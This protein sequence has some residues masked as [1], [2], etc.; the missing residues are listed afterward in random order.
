[1]IYA[2][3]RIFAVSAATFIKDKVRNLVVVGRSRRGS[4]TLI[5]E[6][7]EFLDRLQAPKTMKEIER[8]ISTLA[9]LKEEMLSAGFNAS[10]PEMMLATKKE[11]L[12]EDI[13]SDLPK[14]LKEFREFANLKRYTLN[15]IRVSLA[16]HKIL[17][18][19]MQRGV[20][21]EM[22][23]HL[24]YN[25]QYLYEIIYAGEPA[26]RAYN[27]M[28]SVLSRK[29]EDSGGEYTVVLSLNGDKQTVKLESNQNLGD[30]VKRIYGEGATVLSV[31]KRNN[32]P[33]LVRNRSTRVAVAAAYAKMSAKKIYA[34][35][36]K[37]GP[38]MNEQHAR[39]AAVLAKYGLSSDA[40]ID[41]LEKREA[42]DD[43]LYSKGLLSEENEV[44]KLDPKV[45]ES[46]VRKRRAHNQST[47]QE[48]ERM[49]ADD[50]LHYFVSEPKRVRSSYPLF[51][52]I[53]TDIDERYSFLQ[54][55]DVEK[56]QTIIANKLKLE[57][58]VPMSGKQLGAA[59][60]H[61]HGKSVE[62]CV[63]K[64]KLPASEVKESSAKLAPYL[65]HSSTQAKKFLEAMG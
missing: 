35:A 52:G 38:K 16:S 18:N 60:M 11:F 46:I 15:R 50:V 64:F 40:R 1:L 58:M 19:M 2:E 20:V 49:F 10:Y 27:S 24:P 39:Y 51:P 3:C 28:Q 6:S 44:T 59:I 47:I 62:W 13:A 7:N 42:L 53:S 54:V 29:K 9:G 30:R 43:E 37:L 56:P 34:N 14:Q 32:E 23:Q 41:L 48:A 17:Y 63:D 21:Y 22:A 36:E 5:A 65:K 8:N 4:T 25:G 57:A 61:H 12:D 45:V 26:V 33:Q 55:L 31:T